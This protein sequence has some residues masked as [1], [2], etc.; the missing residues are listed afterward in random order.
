[1]EKLKFILFSIVTLS[2]VGLVGYWAVTTLQS[3]AEYKTGQKIEQLERENENLKDEV[4]KQKNKISLLESKLKVPEPITEKDPEPVKTIVYKYQNLINELQKMADGNVFLKQKSLGGNVGTVQK[5]LNIY[6]N[7]SSR[8]DNDYG[9]GTAKLVADFQK[10][11]G[12][13]AD[14]EAGKNTFL[15]MID[16]LKKQK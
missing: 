8:V 14:G 11:S 2:L 1:M 13:N 4:E 5:F 9:A 15:K 6:N 12:V 7:T 10:A 3:G 16:W